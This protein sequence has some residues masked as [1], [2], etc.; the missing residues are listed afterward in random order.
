MSTPT[1]GQLAIMRRPNQSTDLYLAVYQPPV[2]EYGRVF[3]DA[4][5][6]GLPSE[7]AD[8]YYIAGFTATNVFT[9]GTVKN[10]MTLVFG[11]AEGKEDLGR[12]FVRGKSGTHYDFSVLENMPL[13]SGIYFRVYDFF[14]LWPVFPRVTV[15]GS[16]VI[17]Y[18][19]DYDKAYSNQNSVF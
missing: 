11:S 19:K 9:S 18:Y 8:N 14:E 4:Q 13:V 7:L 16:N 10:G 5:I 15:D 3:P 2:V 12:T 17:T 1:A 6:Q